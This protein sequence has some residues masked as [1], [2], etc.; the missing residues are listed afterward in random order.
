[1]RVMETQGSSSGKDVGKAETKYGVRTEVQD[2]WLQLASEKRVTAMINRGACGGKESAKELNLSIDVLR[3]TGCEGLVALRGLV[4]DNQLTGKCCLIVRIENAVLLAEK[5]RIQ[6]KTPYLSGEVEALSIPEV[7]CD[8]VLG[9][10][11]DTRN[12]DDPDMT[13]IIWCCNDKSP[14]KTGGQA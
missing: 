12:P 11:P 14:S 3:D 2:G 13:A 1:M 4:D 8:L 7:I 9:N 5:S 6:V 10:V